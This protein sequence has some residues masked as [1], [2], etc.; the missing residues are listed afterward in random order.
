MTP[1][2]DD[3]PERGEAHAQ[4]RISAW[5][6]DLCRRRC[7]TPPELV[8]SAGRKERRHIHIESEHI[9][10]DPD[11]VAVLGTAPAAEPGP[12]LDPSV[13]NPV[14]VVSEDETGTE[15]WRYFTPMG[16][17]SSL[18]AAA[19]EFR[20]FGYHSATFDSVATRAGLSASQLRESYPDKQAL[21]HATVTATLDDLRSRTTA[22]LLAAPQPLQQFTNAVECLTLFHA[23]RRD[24]SLLAQA[25][26]RHLEPCAQAQIGAARIAVQ[27]AVDATVRRG[28]TAGL[29]TTQ[30]PRESA[31]SVVSLCMGVSLWFDPEGPDTAELIAQHQVGFCLAVVGY[32][33]H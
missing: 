24:L 6:G 26:S 22:A 15:H 16:L 32:R 13:S 14:Q 21:L 4:S 17:D 5:V 29:F 31:R 18:S 20:Q 33:I 9:A 27:R 10:A 7:S 28:I 8:E 12:A 3:R 30:H 23:Y 19:A 2:T 25:E 1:A 11:D